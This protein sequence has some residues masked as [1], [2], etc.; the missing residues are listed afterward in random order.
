MIKKVFTRMTFTVAMTVGTFTYA[1]AQNSN[2][3]YQDQNVRFTVITDGAL[4]MEY[5]P[6][7]QFTDDRSFIAVNRSYPDAKYQVKEKGK[8][9]EIATDRFHLS[10][11]KGSGKFTDKNLVITSAKGKK[12]LPFIWKPGIK[13]NANLK[14]TYRTLDRYNGDLKDGKP[15]KKMPIEDGLLSRNGW[16]FID[17]SQSYTFDNSDWPWVKERHNVGNT[18]DWYFLAYGHDYKKALKDYTL[19]A[20]KVPMP[21]RYAFGY[22]WSRHW[23]YSD[24]ELR[25]IVDNMHNYGFPLDVLVVDKDWHYTEEGLG[26]WGGYTWNDRLF[27][28]HTQFLQWVKEND[29]NVTF[30][31]H[32]ADG[33]H[34]YDTHYADMARWMGMNPDDG[35]EVEWIGSDKHFMEGW[36]EKMLRPMEKEGVDFWWLDWQQ[37]LND[38]KLTRL[39]NTW[40]LNYTTFT[41]MER[42]RDTR[43]ILYHRWGGLGNHRY[44]IGFSGDTHITWNS[45]DFQPYFNSTASNVLYGYW[46][47]DIGG[48]YKAQY[49]DPELYIR[50]M[51]FGEYSPI[52]RT[53]SSKNANVNKEPWMFTNKQTTILRDIVNNRYA[54]APYIYTMARKTYEEGISLCRPMYYDYPDNEEAYANRNEYMFGDLM[55]VYPI[56]APMTDGVSTK[57]VWLPE[58]ND[59][60]ETASGT[61]LKGGQTVERRFLIDETPVYI[62]A[63]SIIPEYGKVKNLR[64]NDEPIIVTVY[65]GQAD[66]TFTMYEDNGNDKRYATE[67]ATTQLMSKRSANALN[68]TIGARKG[69]YAGMPAKRQFRLKVV[70][71]AVPEKVTADGK[72]I[73]FKYDGNTLS[74]TADIPETDCS[75]AKD[76]CVTY[77]EHALDVADGLTGK[78]RHIQQNVL[79]LKN[80]NAKIILNEALGTMESTGLAITYHPEEFVQRIEA[81]RKNY[82][83]LREALKANK[84]DDEYAEKF[85]R[86]AF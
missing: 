10:Y 36:Y 47:H 54:M 73:K 55:L 56:T 78:F 41:D 46:S 85:V 8:K 86:T 60:Y 68:V 79:D 28:D 58:G 26:G 65:P 30:N 77:P 70:A 34:P 80:H 20:G 43:P 75:V 42:H 74:L 51:Q 45:L 52:L 48:H 22:W 35:K 69:E 16:T 11:V 40:W 84:V 57:K 2:V 76:I 82:E 44:Q 66:G 63:G 1:S 67:Y 59:W 18:Q 9:V 83:N 37:W 23:S 62:K 17:D 5:A 32:P 24:N 61:L 71:T 39:S 81:F 72:E 53:H 14:G 13:D 31:L 7:G 12:N 29:L 64:S 21:P 50:W 3:A 6:D 15:D 4:R 38:K 49:L 25:K 27:P 33:V 19:F